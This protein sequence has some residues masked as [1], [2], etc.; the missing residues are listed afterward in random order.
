[1]TSCRTCCKAVLQALLLV[2]SSHWKQGHKNN[3]ALWCFDG[4]LCNACLLFHVAWPC[5]SLCYNPVP[6]KCK[7]Q[8][9]KLLEGCVPSYW[10][11][12]PLNGKPEGPSTFLAC[13]ADATSESLDG[14]PNRAAS[15]QGLGTQGQHCKQRSFFSCTIFVTLISP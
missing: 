3:H 14:G 13:W 12:L 5:S 15:S 7:Q 9:G 4:V 10:N 8:E 2:N 11:G 1:M 6:D